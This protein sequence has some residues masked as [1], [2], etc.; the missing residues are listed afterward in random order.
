MESFGSF[1]AALRDDA[2]SFARNLTR[3][4]Q[5]ADL[6]VQSAMASVYVRV[7]KAN[8]KGSWPW[9]RSLVYRTMLE[10][11]GSANSREPVAH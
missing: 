6:L 4:H 11:S 7:Q 1:A 5:V 2:H 3:D 10:Q 9:V 8:V